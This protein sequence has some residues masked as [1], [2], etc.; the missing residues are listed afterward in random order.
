MALNGSDNY[1]MICFELF[2]RF[3]AYEQGQIRQEV[4]T[5]IDELIYPIMTSEEKKVFSF[6]VIEEFLS[7]PVSY[8]S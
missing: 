3:I 5:F 2:K 8:I 7:S 4:L 1:S 6:K